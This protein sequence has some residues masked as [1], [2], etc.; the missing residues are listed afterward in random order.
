MAADLVVQRIEREGRPPAG[1]FSAVALKRFL[2]SCGDSQRRWD[3]WDG[4]SVDPHTFIFRN[5]YGMAAPP[6]EFYNGADARGSWNWNFAGQDFASPYVRPAVPAWPPLDPP[7][8]PDHAAL[9][10]RNKLMES[11]GRDIDRRIAG[12]RERAADIATR[13]DPYKTHRLSEEIRDRTCRLTPVQPHVPQK[14]SRFDAKAANARRTTYGPAVEAWLG[15]VHHQRRRE[16][17]RR[18]FPEPA[19]LAECFPM[20]AEESA[21]SAPPTTRTVPR[22]RPR[23]P[24]WVHAVCTHCLAAQREER[25]LGTRAVA[26]QLDP[27]AR[28]CPRCGHHLGYDWTCLPADVTNGNVST[29]Y[30][31]AGRGAVW[32]LAALNET[33]WDRDRLP[34]TALHKAAEAAC[35]AAGVELVRDGD[36]F[37]WRPLPVPG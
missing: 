12:H 15:E 1:P 23:W 28:G 20:Q 6:A 19:G 11:L 26:A 17:I 33:P 14:L 7:R 27:E 10:D 8:A 13:R 22:R 35:L 34:G 32:A 25:A 31:V 4:W 2:R 18:A 37:S 29:W 21:E 16:A 30:E 24:R 3:P 5:P 36:R 9:G